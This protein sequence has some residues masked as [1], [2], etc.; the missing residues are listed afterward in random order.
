M[1]TILSIAELQA[2]TDI[3]ASVQTIESKRLIENV[4]T[5]IPLILNNYFISE[6]IQLQSTVRFNATGRTITLS[7]STEKWED[8]GFLAGDYIYIYG[9]YRNDKYVE[10]ASI[11]NNIITLTSAY[12]VVDEYHNN[13][14]GK[15]ILFARV[16]WPIDVKQVA[17]E[18]CYYDSDVRSKR[19]LGIKSRSLGPLSE[20]FSGI[21]ENP[22]GYPSEI[23][24]KIEHYK[25]CRLN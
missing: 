22:F 24:N 1:A 12:S 25:I 19:T 23:L 15:C 16:D 17:A 3:T 6:D 13:S 11:T 20:S 2:W 14:E 4:E 18:M 21:D 5:R 10:I 7:T 8:Y 9:S